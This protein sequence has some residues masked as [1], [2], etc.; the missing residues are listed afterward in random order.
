MN[1][2]KKRSD[3]ELRQTI[4][5]AKRAV[6]I[7]DARESLL[8]FVQLMMPDPEDPDDSD[9]TIYTVKPHHK[10][11]A[12]TLHSVESG[13]TARAA[14][15]IGP[16]FGKS[17]LA[18]R[19][20]LAWY[21]GRHPHHNIIFGTYSQDFA[22]EYG[23]EVRTIIKSKPYQAVF[24]QVRLQTGS[25]AKNLLITNRG[26]KVAFI[27]RNAA[28]SGK[29]ANLIVVDDPLKNEQEAESPTIRKELHGWWDKVII[30]RARNS[31]RIV[32]IHTRWNEDDEIGRQ[33]D[34][35][36]PSRIKDEMG[37]VVD[38]DPSHEWTM[39]NIPA[40]LEPSHLATVLGVTPEPQTD[41]II[42][43]AFGD[44]PIAALWPEEFSLKTLATRAAANPIAFNALY[45]GKPAPD[46]GAYFKKD[47]LVEYE[48]HELP[49]NLRVYGASDHA[50]SEKQTADYTV[51]GCVGIDEQNHI[52]VLPD[53]VW[54]RMETPRTVEEMLEQ[55]KNHKP[56]MW[57][58]ESELISRSFGP[59]L[60]K[61][62]TE[63]NAYTMIDPVR[64]AADKRARA[65]A[66]Q[67]RMAMKVVHFPKFAP[68]WNDA[69]S[70]LLKFPFA[71]HDDLVDWL[72]HIGMGLTKE[73]AATT[74]EKK[75]NVLRV[76][77]F[78]WIKAQSLAQ[79]RRDKVVK[80]SAGW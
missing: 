1:P 10:L 37:K 63:T 28:G 59:F 40:V 48:R 29:P 34:P 21:I 80:M 36:H 61:R 57:W 49:G 43:R 17:Q 47:W 45:M 58:M 72:A 67:G 41:P 64:P 32:L 77:S 16:Q 19:M 25:A 11:I 6:A 12:D 14:I 74:V 44:K 13:E 31:T 76:G 78:A 52:W 27:G 39:L 4:K 15:S 68:W 53:L 70:Q 33:C 22:E 24:P 2:L 66:I 51:I 50:V 55:F 56:L 69:K 26:G 23:G 46:D 60:H 9:R 35:D 65:R 71:T 20:F 54:D 79:A 5:A 8:R 73:V 3:D 7:G 18:S 30:A 62:M 38:Y 75:D 42:V